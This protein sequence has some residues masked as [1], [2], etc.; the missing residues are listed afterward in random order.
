M[1]SILS[2]GRFRIQ[3]VCYQESFLA[4]EGGVI[5]GFPKLVDAHIEV[6]SKYLTAPLFNPHHCCSGT[7][8]SSI[9]LTRKSN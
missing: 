5:V 2:P 8:K 6:A 7:S 4:Y 3:N 1:T 9:Q